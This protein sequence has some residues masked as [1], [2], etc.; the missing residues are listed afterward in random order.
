M[1]V[2][3]IYWGGVRRLVFCVGQQALYQQMPPGAWVLELNAAEVF[4]HAAGRVEVIGALLEAEGLE[5]HA[6]F[7]S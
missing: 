4:A 5:A 2:G 3:A 7:W 1:C 6:G